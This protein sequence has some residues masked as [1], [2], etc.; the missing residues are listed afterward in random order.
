MIDATTASH[1]LP[2][3]NYVEWLAPRLDGLGEAWPNAIQA[4]SDQVAHQ[5][6]ASPTAYAH[7][8]AGINILSRYAL[9]S[10]A[11]QPEQAHALELACCR[12]VWGL[13]TA[14]SQPEAKQDEARRFLALLAAAL[15]AGRCHLYPL[16]GHAL[17][18]PGWHQA[19]GARVGWLDGDVAYLDGRAAYA[20]VSGYARDQGAAI[21]ATQR[22]IFRQLHQGG[23]LART[24]TEGDKRRLQVRKRVPGANHPRLY[25]VPLAALI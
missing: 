7:L 4:L 2:T 18:V 10:S 1:A 6:M 3:L 9:E 5:G 16:R 17:P 19:T 25:A 14:Q 13:L 12:N 24:A 21:N 15:S 11:L 22:A 23:G 20:A 8:A